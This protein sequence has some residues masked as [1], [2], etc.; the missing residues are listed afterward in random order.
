MASWF[1]LLAFTVVLGLRE[2]GTEQDRI[3]QQDLRSHEKPPSIG[4]VNLSL[5]SCCS[6]FLQ[7]VDG[8]GRFVFTAADHAGGSADAHMSFPLTGRHSAPFVCTNFA[9]WMRRCMSSPSVAHRKDFPRAMPIAAVTPS[10]PT[11]MPCRTSLSA[12]NTTAS[13]WASH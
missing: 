10:P 1:L 13:G 6:L 9:E 8:V 2:G 7:F 4:T 12:V 5:D 11:D 3:L